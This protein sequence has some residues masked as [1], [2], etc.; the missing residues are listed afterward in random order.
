M[1]ASA[2]HEHHHRPHWGLD[3]IDGIESASSAIATGEA[4]D[5]P[6]VEEWCADDVR[7]AWEALLELHSI[8]V[9]VVLHGAFAV[10]LAF[11]GEP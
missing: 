1:T 4:G 8:G 9:A 7:R 5:N 6:P 3:G 10:V 11:E 2:L